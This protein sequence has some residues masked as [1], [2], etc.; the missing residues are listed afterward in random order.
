[1]STLIVIL[2][3]TKSVFSKSFGL[4]T[5]FKKL[6]LAKALPTTISND[7]YNIVNIKNINNG[8]LFMNI[9]IIIYIKIIFFFI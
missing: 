1:M 2:G 8:W 5:S 7:L 9:N 3:T 6:S 4:E